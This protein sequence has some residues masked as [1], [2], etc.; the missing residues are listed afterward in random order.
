MTAIKNLFFSLLFCGFLHAQ[1]NIKITYTN[2]VNPSISQIKSASPQNVQNHV[3]KR[4]QNMRY[5]SYMTIE[6]YEV[7]Y[8]T[9]AKIIDNKQSEKIVTS[10]TKY[11]EIPSVQITIPAKKYLK[12]SK[13]NS[14]ATYVD[15]KLIR[16]KLPAINWKK[17]SRQKEIL[18][19]NCSE[20]KGVLK[21]KPV[22]IWYTTEIKGIGSPEKIPFIKG[23]VL[24]YTAENRSAVAT[25]VEFDQPAIKNF[26]K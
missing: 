15:K 21:N 18:G 3:V 26:F 8:E 10:A 9:K 12:N 1:S 20:A 22:S 16:E 14:I 19:Y 13:Q 6:E 11:Y 7:Y 17:T 4:V 5:L 25:K 24:E 23:V 2:A